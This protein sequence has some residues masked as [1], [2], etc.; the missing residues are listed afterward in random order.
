MNS[1]AERITFFDSITKDVEIVCVVLML[2]GSIQGTR[3]AV[4]N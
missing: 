2:T 3:N 4:K 1:I